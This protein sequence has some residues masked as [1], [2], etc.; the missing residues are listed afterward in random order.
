MVFFWAFFLFLIVLQ[1]KIDKKEKKNILL[2]MSLVL[3]WNIIWLVLVQTEL[4]YKGVYTYGSDANYY[5]SEMLKALKSNNPF[6]TAFNSRLAPLFVVFGTFI[7]KTSPNYSSIWIKLSNIL[8]LET[9]LILIYFWM[10]N[11]IKNRFILSNLILFFGMNGIVTWTVLRELKDTLFIFFVI[12]DLVVTEYLL[13]KNKN[14]EVVLF[15]SIMIFIF[16]KLRMFAVA[17]PILFL[18]VYIFLHRNE[19]KRNLYFWISLFSALAILFEHKLI[20]WFYTG[21]LY[22]SGRFKEPLSV[23]SSNNM[24][25]QFAIAPFRFVV[26][27][28]PIRALAGSEVFVV[29]TN[30]GNILIFLGAFL[31][32]LFLPILFMILFFDFKFIFKNLYIFIPPFFILF[33]YSFM[34]FGTGDTRLRATTYVLFIPAFAQYIEYLSGYKVKQVVYRYFV[35][36]IFIWTLGIILSLLSVS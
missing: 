2:V 1:L 32:W 18:L 12:L 4:F 6:Y 30:M 36:G 17:L 13:K 26:G 14:F 35:A 34:Y 33:M 21:F 31:W 22:Y 10:R 11:H 19:I 25:L 20:V 23:F 28:G 27:P 24:L 8:L 15:E 29:T 7:L 9:A 3:V 5:Y 16:Y